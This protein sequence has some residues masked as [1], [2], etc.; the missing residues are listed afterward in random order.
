MAK[1]LLARLFGGIGKSNNK[2]RQPI[3]RSRIESTRAPT[4]PPKTHLP[5]PTSNVTISTNPQQSITYNNEDNSDYLFSDMKDKITDMNSFI[6]TQNNN[7]INL[8]LK[9]LNNLKDRVSYTE[10]IT[11]DE[12]STLS[13]STSSSL[14][15]QDAL[16]S[17]ISNT[18]TQSEI[19]I[20]SNDYKIVVE[21]QQQESSSSS[22][23]DSNESLFDRRFSVADSDSTS[24]TFHTLPN[25]TSVLV[26]PKNEMLNFEKQFSDMYI[27][28]L[29]LLSK[30]TQEHSP[31]HALTLFQHIANNGHQ[32]YQNLNERTK[33]LVSF[34]QYRTGR[35]LYE[36]VFDYGQEN[37]SPYHSF[38]D[39]KNKKHGLLYLG[40]SSKNGNSRA[41][42]I[43]GFYAERQG[44]ID[45]ACQFYHQAAMAGLLSAQVAFGNAL[46]FRSNGVSGFKTK[47][48]ISMLENAA[49]MVTL[50][51]PRFCCRL[52]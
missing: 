18:D 44:N 47:D 16:F 8:H 33:L 3:K 34:A 32:N 13:S 25:S 26:S 17:Y 22:N 50:P 28:G 11:N 48:A 45:Q 52:H 5:Q 39:D 19:S 37:S 38:D 23:Y 41:S 40:E 4:P 10:A 20:Y 14:S 24:L 46:L 49:N 12:F 30:N 43:L 27:E 29:R 35:M 15:L 7:D 51:L 36:C 2:Q 1:G 42:F 21:S 31:A 6:N 9:N